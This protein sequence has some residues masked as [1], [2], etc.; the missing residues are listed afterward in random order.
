MDSEIVST[1]RISVKEILERFNLKG[2]LQTFC[3]PSK[4]S[5]ILTE[6]HLLI[7]LKNSGDI[8]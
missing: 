2:E 8:K 7:K 6:K 5:A 1:H 3:T 4:Q